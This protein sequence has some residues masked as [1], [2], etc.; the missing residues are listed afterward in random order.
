MLHHGDGVNTTEDSFQWTVTIVIIHEGKDLVNIV[1][2]S[3]FQLLYF[4]AFFEKIRRL[5]D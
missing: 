4:K 3:T 2:S 1:L 5:E